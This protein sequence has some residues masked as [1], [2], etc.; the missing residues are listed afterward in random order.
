MHCSVQLPAEP[1]LDILDHF[2]PVKLS[3][4]AARLSKKGL[5]WLKRPDK[6][7]IVSFCAAACQSALIRPLQ[8]EGD[9]RGC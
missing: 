3:G 2:K 5:Y 9:D 4:L 7:V 8:S 1:K 6:T